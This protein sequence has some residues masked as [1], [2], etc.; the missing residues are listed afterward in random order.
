MQIDTGTAKTG[1]IMAKEKPKPELQKKSIFQASAEELQDI[2]NTN[3]FPDNITLEGIEK[4]ADFQL[5]FKHRQ[6]P[7]FIAAFLLKGMLKHNVLTESEDIKKER[8]ELRKYELSLKEQKLNI[9]TAQ[10]GE[11]KKNLER[12]EAKIDILIQGLRKETI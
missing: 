8:F 2:L 6:N 3:Q 1:G 11:V 10:I 12:I 9:Q 4:R 5:M 7:K